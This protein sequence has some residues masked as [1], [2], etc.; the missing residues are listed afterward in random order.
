MGAKLEML[1]DIKNCKLPFINNYSQFKNAFRQASDTKHCYEWGIC[2][3]FMNSRMCEGKMCPHAKYDPQKSY[4]PQCRQQCKA[5][6]DYTEKDISTLEHDCKKSK[7]S[8]TKLIRISE[9]T[10]LM[11]L[12]KSDEVDLR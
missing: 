3:W 8:V 4:P 10:D 9:L 11:P 1:Q 5:P 2:Q 6:A 7:A 12:Y